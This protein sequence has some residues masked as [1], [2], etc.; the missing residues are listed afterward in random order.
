MGIWEYGLLFVSVVGGGMLAFRFSGSAQQALKLALSFSGAYILGITI[1]HLMPGVFDQGGQAA[2]FWILAGFFL[3]LL[4]EQL[5]R[6]VEHGHVHAH[7]RERRSFAVQVMIGL[8]LHAFLEGLPLTHFEEFHAAH[9]HHE[10]GEFQL[11]LGILLHKL[12]AAFALVALLIRSGFNRRVA[13]ACLLIF[14]SMSP[15]GAFSASYFPLDGEQVAY[16]LSF[17]IGSFLH[18]STTIL[19]EADDTHQHRVSFRKLLVILLGIGLALGA[20]FV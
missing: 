4:L 1:M 3:Q 7:H 16:L 13:W 18:I 6:G 5:S 14:A 12:P 19:F 2:S 20:D 9:H 8:S 17:V 15:L 11:L 10:R